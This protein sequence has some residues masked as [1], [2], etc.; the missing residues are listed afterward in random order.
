MWQIQSFCF[1]SCF[2]LFKCTSCPV[3]YRVVFVY[4]A[5]SNNSIVHFIALAT[6][7]Q[8]LGVKADADPL[9]Q[10]QLTLEG[11]LFCRDVGSGDDVVRQYAGCPLPLLRW[12]TQLQMQGVLE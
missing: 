2:I 1:Q 3:T 9:P 10:R 8:I 11:K 7:L 12:R 6:Y 5:F 4:C